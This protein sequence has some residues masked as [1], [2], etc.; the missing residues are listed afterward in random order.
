MTIDPYVT[1]SRTIFAP[2]EKTFDRT[3]AIPL[4]LIFPRV[5]EAP[6]IVE[7]SVT[8]DWTRTGQ[9]RVNTLDDGTTSHE[10][11]LSVIRPHSFSYRNDQL[12]SPALISL[13]ESFAGFWVF[14][15]LGNGTTGI[16][17]TYAFT[18]VSDDVRDRVREVMVPRYGAR[19]DNA[20]HLL[21][22][23]IEK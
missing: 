12:T 9:T 11:M 15:D 2:I 8:T 6:G 3:I 17:W 7:S 5:G 13:V 1:V 10:T 21:K 16:E 20:L 23:E 14:R 19:L 22:A 18:P 4:P